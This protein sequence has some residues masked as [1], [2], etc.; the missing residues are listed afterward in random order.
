MLEA[1]SINNAEWLVINCN[2][3]SEKM[4]D[5]SSSGVVECVRLSALQHL[6]NCR[7]LLPLALVC[8][9]S[10]ST[11]WRAMYCLGCFVITCLQRLLVLYHFVLLLPLEMLSLQ[12]LQQA[13]LSLVAFTTKYSQITLE[14]HLPIVSHRNVNMCSLMQ[15]HMVP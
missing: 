13:L 11:F 6:S 8:D 7:L 5:L 14:I 10:F 3:L 2:H 1:N 4:M 12:T 9:C 15:T